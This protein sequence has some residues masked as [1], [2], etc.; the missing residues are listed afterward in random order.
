MSVLQVLKKFPD[1][2]SAGNMKI[3]PDN[4][5][6]LMIYKYIFHMSAII[7]N[8]AQLLFHFFITVNDFEYTADLFPACQQI[9]L[10]G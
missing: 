6:D 2:V 3:C 8:Q 9:S 5:I 1:V 10:I 7:H 4:S